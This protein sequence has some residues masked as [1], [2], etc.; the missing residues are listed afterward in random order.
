MLVILLL[1]ETSFGVVAALCPQM[2][3]VSMDRDQMVTTLMNNYGVPGRDQY[4]VAVDFAQTLVS[5]VRLKVLKII[6][7]LLKLCSINIQSKLRSAKI[8]LNYFKKIS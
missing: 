3:G 4:T 8:D 1:V 2:V 7:K 6:I 5:F